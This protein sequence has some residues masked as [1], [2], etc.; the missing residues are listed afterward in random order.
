MDQNKQYDK[1]VEKIA[2]NITK[3]RKA[4]GWTQEDMSDHGYSYRHYQRIESGKHSPSLV[5][6]FRLGQTFKVDPKDFL[7]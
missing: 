7:K 6:L 2:A 5:T 1:F 4:K 3:A